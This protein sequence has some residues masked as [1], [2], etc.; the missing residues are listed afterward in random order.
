MRS[1]THET[2]AWSVHP[3]VGY[4]PSPR[5][6]LWATGGYG[7]GGVDVEENMDSVCTADH[8]RRERDIMLITGA[9]GGSGM[10]FDR[11][12]GRGRVSLDA[13]G[14]F[15]FARII[16]DGADG[17]DADGG[18][19]RLGLE[20]KAS[21]PVWM[22][23]L[24]GS[25][26]MA[27]RG[28]FGD[29]VRGSGFEVA[30]GIK[31]GVPSIGLNIDAEARALLGHSDDVKERGVTGDIRWSPGGT[32][33]G[34]FLSFRPYWGATNDKRDTLWEQG[35]SEI[36]S[37]GSRELRYEV[38]AGYGLPL[39]REIGLMKMFIRTD[40]NGGETTARSGGVDV[41][42]TNGMNIGYETVDGLGSTETEHK[43]YIKLNK[44]F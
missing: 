30:G 32:E 15:A 7:M 2:T 39:M 27:Y 42:M 31:V 23:N 9:A 14:D 38:E 29:A 19:V 8:C 36:Y 21:R 34:P 16:E 25:F 17:L 44:E 26:E 43:G 4:K 22:G 33:K 5:T 10:L 11:R 13:V 40:I 37:D 6:L 3:Y 20:M 12:V 1:G 18:T 24:G 28:D 35:V 41:E